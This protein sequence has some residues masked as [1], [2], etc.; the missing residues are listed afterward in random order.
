MKKKPN[1]LVVWVILAAS[2]LII[3]L[4]IGLV[5]MSPLDLAKLDQLS[6]SSTVYDRESELVAVIA[7]KERRTNVPLISVPRDVQNAFLAAED[8]RFYDHFGIDPYRMGGALLANMKSGGFSQGASTI[9]QQLI[10]LTH[11]TADKTIVRKL[12]EVFMAMRLETMLSKDQILERYLNTVYFGA[13]AYGVQSAAQ[14]YF[15]VDADKLTLSQ[16]ALLAAIIKSPSTYAPHLNPEKAKQRRDLVLSEMTDYQFIAQGQA[17]AAKAEPI[18]ILTIQQTVTRFPWAVDLATE[19]AA[20]ALDISIDELISGGY[21]VYTSIDQGVQSQAEALFADAKNFPADAK[22][23][24][25]AQAALVSLDNAD[26]AVLAVIGGRDYEVRRGLNR[27]TGISRQPGSAFKPVSVYAAAIDQYGYLPVNMVEDVERDFGNGY[28]PRNVGN[29]YHGT[30]TLRAS[31][32]RS[33]NA[34]SVDLMTKVGIPAARKYAESAGIPLTDRDNNLSLALGSLTDGVSPVGLGAAYAPLANGGQAVQAHI[35]TQ[36]VDRDEQVVYQYRAAQKRVMSDQSA[37]MLTS[38]LQSAVDWGSAQKLKAVGGEVAAKTGTVGFET[39]GNRDIWTVAYSPRASVTVWMGFDQPD[40]NHA[41]PDSAGGSNQPAALC[42]KLMTAEK[43]ALV[44]GRFSMPKGL[45]EV[46]IDTRALDLTHR[47]MLATVNTPKSMTLSEIFRVGQEPTEPSTAWVAPMRVFDLAGEL[48]SPTSVRLQ[49]TCVQE[50][51]IY[52]V[53]RME[54]QPIVIA[55]LIGEAGQQLVL[56]DDQAYEGAT[57]FVIPVHKELLSEGITLEGKPSETLV[58][59]RPFG[60]RDWI[61]MPTPTPAPEPVAVP[62]E[63]ALF[64]EAESG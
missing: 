8:A 46:L 15:G 56:T 22:D 61:A 64:G 18:R 50:D 21:K 11:L 7:G 41:L 48:I 4:G 14:I 53:Y 60:F 43:T 33:L 34:A 19:E 39:G 17:D 40:K 38:M 49:F 58:P 26:G 63:D 30:V 23:G 29:T 36:I 1:R 47:P 59:K 3:A 2:L 20:R 13:G 55:E 35:V 25:K 10:K 28:T 12:S 6:Q 9:T 51:A 45:T 5:F 52:R 27:A 24:A 31:L 16:G 57:Y 32:A 42:A 44:Q 37:Y 62:E 54:A